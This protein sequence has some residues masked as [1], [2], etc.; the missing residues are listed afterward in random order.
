[1]DFLGYLECGT[2]EVKNPLDK[3]SLMNNCMFEAKMMEF[4]FY[5]E[6]LEET[7]RIFPGII[8]WDFWRN[9]ILI[10]AIGV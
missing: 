9:M 8:W 5:W 3:N 4:H 6:N 1:M 2:L 10:G 7:N